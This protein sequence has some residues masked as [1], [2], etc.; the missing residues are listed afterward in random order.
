M[1]S[2]AVRD[3]MT[4]DVLTVPPQAS[5]K[6][7]V[8]TLLG[9]GVDA[10]PVV[11]GDGR[12]LGVV[13]LSDLTCHD[14][15]PGGWTELLLGGRERREQRR[16]ARGRT[17]ADLMRAPAVTV[18]PGTSV[19]EALATMTH[20]GVGR[21]VVAEGGR[22]VG[23][24]TRSDVLRDYL[25]DDDALRRDAETAVREAVGERGTRLDVEVRD[26]VA[27]LAGWAELTSTAWAAEA[28]VRAVPGI[29]DVEEQVLTD[30][31]DTVVHE[32]STRGPFV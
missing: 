32:L 29:V 30:V 22:V 1:R 20:A 8:R 3:C 14:E 4:T 10:A 21:V 6:A 18:E 26:G 15:Q 16:K 9:R 2:T 7:V 11:D 19:C 25:R 13:S 24:L 17:A 28:A 5:F 12:L 23:V 27:L 31:D